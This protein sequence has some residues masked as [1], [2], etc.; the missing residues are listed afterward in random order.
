MM[1]SNSGYRSGFIAV[2]GRPNVGKSTLLNRL[3]GQKIAAVSPKPQTTRLQQ[4]GILTF[5]DAQLIF[6][7]T[8]GLHHPHHRLGQYMNQTAQEALVEADLAMLVVDGSVTP[9]EEEDRLLLKLL[10]DLDDPP[11][12]TIVL[13]KIDLLSDRD[14]QHSSE[15]Y[16]SL[17]P[18]ADLIPVS[19]SRGTGLKQLLDHLIS[20]LPEG[21][22]YYPEDQITDIFERDIAADLIRAAAMNNL[23]HELPHSLAVRMDEYKER[24]QHGAYIAATLFVERESQKAIVIGEGGK[25]IKRISME[26]RREIQA[27]SGRKVYLDL[28]VKVRKNWRNDENALRLF[29]FK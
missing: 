8:P 2:M 19:A 7:D 3:L 4:L 29:G 13:N 18:E 5:D 27:M 23:R 6:I 22:Q 11:P 16:Q 9:P 17:V 10:S 12:L 28:R 25:M 14:I 21:P 26:A 15:V 20:Q 1:T 24:N